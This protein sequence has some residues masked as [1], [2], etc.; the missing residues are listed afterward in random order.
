MEA[1]KRKVTAKLSAQSINGRDISQSSSPSLSPPPQ[2]VVR[3]KISSTARERTSSNMHGSNNATG[4]ASSTFRGALCP[5]IGSTARRSPSPAK[6]RPASPSNFQPQLRPTTVRASFSKA[7]TKLPPADRARHGSISSVLS[8][9]ADAPGRTTSAPA[10]PLP[11]RDTNRIPNGD[12]SP[13]VNV[14]PGSGSFRIK[15]KVSGIA[16]PAPA[17]LSTILSPPSPPSSSVTP[18]FPPTNRAPRTRTTT[19]ASRRPSASFSVHQ[20]HSAQPVPPS[21]SH[22]QPQL[23]PLPTSPPASN[24]SFSSHSSA[25]A[26]ASSAHSHST[27]TGLP[28]S[29]FTSHARSESIPMS[30]LNDRPPSP[31]PNR[32]LVARVRPGTRISGGRGRGRGWTSGSSVAGEPELASSSRSA[33]RDDRSTDGRESSGDEARTRRLQSPPEDDPEDDVRAEAKS[34]R[35]GSFLS[36]CRPRDYDTLSTHYQCGPRSI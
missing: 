30:A 27:S 3:A 2:V 17:S 9:S 31:R 34:N 35:K 13:S 10:T 4:G 26:S 11:R 36:D 12:Y 21:V 32:T 25:S 19:V 24:V 23:V 16:R 18:H 15:S 7:S 14:D 20:S 1:P 6:M 28:S 5:Q 29:P 8:S 33:E 22:E